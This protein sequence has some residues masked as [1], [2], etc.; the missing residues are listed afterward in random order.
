MATPSCVLVPLPN[1]SK[2]TSDLCSVYYWLPSH[3]FTTPVSY[4]GEACSSASAASRS[5]TMNVE[6][7]WNMLSDAP[8]LLSALLSTAV[9]IDRQH[10]YRV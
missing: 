10:M 6:L 2:M 5:S 1:S 9:V 8:I 4:R 3:A 7:A